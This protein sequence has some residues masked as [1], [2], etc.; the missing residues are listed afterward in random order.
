MIGTIAFRLF[1][2]ILVRE[3]EGGEKRD[4]GDLGLYSIMGIQKGINHREISV[5][6]G[7]GMEETYS[8]YAKGRGRTSLALFFLTNAVR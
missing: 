2:T 5:M 6:Q 4:V 1:F 3:I 7:K 8:S